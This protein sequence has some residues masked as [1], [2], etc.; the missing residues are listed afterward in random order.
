MA[1]LTPD[2]TSP[3]PRAAAEA[4][5]IV[6]LHRG[7]GNKLFQFAAGHTLA[8]RLGAPLHAVAGTGNELVQVVLGDAWQPAT[9]RELW[10][11][12]IARPVPDPP[13][14]L[15]PV[16]RSAARVRR[17]MS[18]ADC[19]VRHRPP[20]RFEPLTPHTYDPVFEQL[21]AP[22]YLIGYFQHRAYWEDAI[23]DVTAVARPALGLASPSDGRARSSRAPIVGVHVRRADF[24]DAGW[25]LGPAYYRR[26]LDRLGD[27]ARPTLRLVGDD[28]A[29]LAD[30]ARRL[31][32]AGHDVEP[33]LDTGSA[34]AA[35]PARDPMI[36]DLVR[37][38]ECDHLVLSNSTFAWWGAALGDPPA[39]TATER[40]V[41][42]PATWT[43]GH[44]TDVVLRPGWETVPAGT[45]PT[46]RGFD[47]YEPARSFDEWWSLGA[48]ADR[49]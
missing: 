9:D 36:S 31:Q 5:V 16:V 37:L 15:D 7:L 32:A 11:C 39:G 8:T 48:P 43:S 42:L 49:P 40:R 18:R 1:P 30:L 45:D 34:T 6:R 44:A 33:P 14:L 29:F 46:A 2:G 20:R 35:A 22:C 26:A 13:S 4:P 38:A 17:V 3:F 10:R 41:L 21:R 28:P 47:V 24:I 12:G 27:L 25:A 19:A 23:D